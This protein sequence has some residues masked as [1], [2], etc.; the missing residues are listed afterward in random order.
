MVTDRWDAHLIERWNVDD[1]MGQPMRVGNMV[2]T[3]VGAP[4]GSITI[5]DTLSVNVYQALSAA[6]Q[7]RPDREVILSDSGNFPS[8]LFMAQGLLAQLGQ[9]HE[10]RIVAPEDVADAIT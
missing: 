10:L 2:D 6:V 5:G 4:E 1:W 3:L 8:G 7:V 9:G